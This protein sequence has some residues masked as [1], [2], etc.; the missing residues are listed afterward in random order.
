MTDNPLR[1]AAIRNARPWN[2]EHDGY[3][4]IFLAAL[5]GI[6]A[7]PALFGAVMQGSPSAAIEFAD[8]IVLAAIEQRE[9]PF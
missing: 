5:T 3:R 9:L 2:T 6:C 7:N 8:G 1:E 4:A